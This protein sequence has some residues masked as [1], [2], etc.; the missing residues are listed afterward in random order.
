MKE[1][2]LSNSEAYYTLEYRHGPMSLADDKTMIILL[3]NEDT[4]DGDKKLLEEM[5]SYGAVILAV[6]GMASGR[7]GAAD[8]TLNLDYGYDSLQNGAMIGFIGQMMGYYLAEKK[9]LNADTPRHL[10]QAI[11]IQEN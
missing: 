10:S 11:V 2:S 1:M 4:A 7:Y 5:K 8:Y 6:G 3:G 9:G